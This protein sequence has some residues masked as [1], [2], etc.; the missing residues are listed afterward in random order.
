MKTG[1]DSVSSPTIRYS[2]I[3][4]LI[5]IVLDVFQYHTSPKNIFFP[6]SNYKQFSSTES[7]ISTKYSLVF[8]LNV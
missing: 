2:H 1:E 3:Y 6:S 4:I 7:T 8:I 5:H